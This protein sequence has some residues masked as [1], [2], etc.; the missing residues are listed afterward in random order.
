MYINNFLPE[1]FGITN[2]VRSFSENLAK[3]NVP[4]LSLP[5]YSIKAL[6]LDLAYREEDLK[7]GRHHKN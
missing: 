1:V 2:W 4:E 5:L 6:K 7:F 3:R